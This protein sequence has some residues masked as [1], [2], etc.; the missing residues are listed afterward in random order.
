MPIEIVECECELPYQISISNK[1]A[2]HKCELVKCGISV[3]FIAL[4]SIQC[5]HIRMCCRFVYGASKVYTT[6]IVIEWI[7]STFYIALI[8]LNGIVKC[9]QRQPGVFC[10]NIW[11]LWRIT[12]GLNCTESHK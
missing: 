5:L 7:N 2:Y 3:L 6:Q 11:E 9:K 1:S 4:Y 12:L 8:A 10:M